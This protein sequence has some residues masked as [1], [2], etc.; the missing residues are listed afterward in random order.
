[1]T[2]IAIVSAGAMG[3]AIAKRLVHAGCTIYTNLDGRS[4]AAHQRALDTGT[5][6][7]PLPTLLSRSTWIVPQAK[8]SPLP[9]SSS[10]SNANTTSALPRAFV[11]CNDV[12][13]KMI[14]AGSINA[15]IVGTPPRDGWDPTFYACSGS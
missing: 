11:E 12:N 4:H 2:T 3:S 6:N 14:P 7:V 1:M 15:G 10:G 13:P 8:H 9:S 5:I